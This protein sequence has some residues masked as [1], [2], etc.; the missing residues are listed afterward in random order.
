MVYGN[1]KMEYLK[2]LVRRDNIITDDGDNVEVFEL[3][4]IDEKAFKEWAVHFR[5]NYCYISLN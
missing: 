2:S 5:Q 3:I 4:E 1:R